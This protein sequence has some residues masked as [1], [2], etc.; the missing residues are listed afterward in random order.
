VAGLITT[1]FTALGLVS[2]QPG[3][4]GDHDELLMAANVPGLYRIAMVFDALG[5][6]AMGGL[7]VIVGMALRRDATV[8]GPLG[9][10]LGVTAIAGIIGA[11]LRLSVVGDLGKQL[12]AGGST[13]EAGLLSL[14]R[15]VDWIISA[16]FAAGLLTVGLAF[17]VVGSAALGVAWIPRR[18]A[19]LVV[20]P[21]VTSL[22]LLIGE[23]AFEVFLFPVLLPHVVLLA[24]AGLAMAAAWWRAPSPTVERLSSKIGT[25]ASRPW[26]ARSSTRSS[27]RS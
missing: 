19:W 8:R 24:V 9:V 27:S 4:G 3:I 10:A 11:F 1:F 12:A 21:G 18:I 5:W 22:A 13:N 14:Y 25:P 26:D 23:V 16:H 17:L 20:L 2:S 7:I 15:T 6:L